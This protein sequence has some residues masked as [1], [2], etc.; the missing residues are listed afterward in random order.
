MST[1]TLTQEDV[2]NVNELALS[3]GLSLPELTILTIQGRILNVVDKIKSI[4]PIL[5]IPEIMKQIPV[6][7]E[8][9]DE[10][11]K[12]QIPVMLDGK[13]V[14]STG[15]VTSRGQALLKVWRMI[16]NVEQTSQLN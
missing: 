9:I 15:E 11:L 4:S 5:L 7:R 10:Q 8:L 1:E 6:S 12:I 14:T 13:L 3:L 2:D 16:Y